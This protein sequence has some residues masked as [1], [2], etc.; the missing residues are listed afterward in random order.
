MRQ[1]PLRVDHAPN[2]DYLFVEIPLQKGWIFSTIC[3]RT[4]QLKRDNM[5]GNACDSYI[6]LA[7]TRKGRSPLAYGL[8]HCTQSGKLDVSR[9]DKQL[10]T[11][12]G[13]SWSAKARLCWTVQM[14]MQRYITLRLRCTNTGKDRVM[15]IDSD[16]CETNVKHISQ[17]FT[18]YRYLVEVQS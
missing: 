18:W 12:H 4:K 3:Y 14:L 8:L 1:R 16:G 6:A 11:W 13:K 15:I 7:M 17:A 10:I 5:T 9:D 2:L